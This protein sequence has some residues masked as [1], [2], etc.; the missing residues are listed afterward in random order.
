MTPHSPLALLPV[1]LL[2]VPCY[3]GPQED[4]GR[5]AEL[6]GR[7]IAALESVRDADTAAAATPALAA[8]LA[9][10]AAM[11]RSREAEKEL[12]EYIDNTDGV[13][14]PFIELLQRLAVQFIRLAEADYYG[15]APLRDALA[16]QIPDGVGAPASDG[17]DAPAS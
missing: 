1:L 5:L 15:C 11:D 16:P 3:A 13:K 17:R 7:E 4:C 10:L 14:Q 12:W 9:A 2:S 6:L 8:A